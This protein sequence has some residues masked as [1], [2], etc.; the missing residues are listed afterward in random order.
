MNEEEVPG[1]QPLPLS[2]EI[3]WP[4]QATLEERREDMGITTP[5]LP[6]EPSSA[7]ALNDVVGSQG[8]PLRPP[9]S[10]PQLTRVTA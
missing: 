2:A 6:S 5:S 7:Q 9:D 4:S 3:N 8:Y 10:H 1:T